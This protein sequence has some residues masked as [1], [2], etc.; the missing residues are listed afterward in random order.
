MKCQSCNNETFVDR[1]DP[2]T[3]KV[4]YVCMNPK[5]PEYRISKALTGEVGETQINK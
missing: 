2:K 4:Y 3:G 5:C 1:V